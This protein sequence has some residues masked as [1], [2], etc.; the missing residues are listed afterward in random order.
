MQSFSNF[1]PEPTADGSFTFFSAEFGEA[2]H[3]H[4]GARQEAALKFVQPTHLKQKA[5]QPSLRLLDICYGLGYNT[6][7][8]LEMIWTVNPHCQIEWVGLELDPTVPQA[9]IAHDLLDSWP[10]VIQELLATLV[11]AQPVQTEHLKAQ[12]LIGDA[13]QTIQQ[14][15]QL[16]WLTQNSPVAKQA[17]FDVIFLDPFSPPHCPQ[18]WTVEF[19]DHVASCL[20]PSGRLATY[21]CAAAVRTALTIAGLQIG[22]TLPVGRRSPGTVASLTATDLSPLSVQEQEHLLTR[23]A[24]PYRDP[25]LSDST[26][27]IL[28]RRQMEQQTCALEPTSQWKKRWSTC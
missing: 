12:L 1:I 7:A 16:D 17:K 26:A 14:I 3:S 15:K 11:I 24:V 23:A 9:A 27:V 6:A 21:S 2:F 8:A 20:K 13:R 25:D 4:Q 5:N 10:V 18:L 22:S 28:Q 19:L